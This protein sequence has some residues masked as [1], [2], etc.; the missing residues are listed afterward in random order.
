MMFLNLIDSRC[1][2]RNMFE[3]DRLKRV[4]KSKENRLWGFK[5]QQRYKNYR[6]SQFFFISAPMSMMEIFPNF[7]KQLSVIPCY[8]V[9]NRF[10]FQ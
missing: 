7:T 10:I 3:I 8:S 1:N 2:Y 4:E 5:S 9:F 6:E